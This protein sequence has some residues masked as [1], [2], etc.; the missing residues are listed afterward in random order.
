[1]SAAPWNM[2]VSRPTNESAPYVFIASI[3][4]PRAPVP[5][6]GF[7]NAVGNAST[8]LV[9]APVVPTI[10]RIPSMT[11]SSAPLA[12][13]IPTATSMAMRNGIMRIA[14]LNPSLAPSMNASYT[15]MRFMAASATKADM[16]PSSMTLEPI[17]DQYCIPSGE[18]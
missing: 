3:M 16:T 2:Q 15:L 6:S 7:M 11:K 18:S 13:N 17:F 14:V 10:H 5:L 8:K 12:L 9:S 1:M 4:N